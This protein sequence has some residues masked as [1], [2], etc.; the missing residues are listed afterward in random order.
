MCRHTREP[1]VLSKVSCR[2]FHLNVDRF[3]QP[4]LLPV[5]PPKH[6]WLGQGQVRTVVPVPRGGHLPFLG[7]QALPPL[8]LT[9]GIATPTKR[10]HGRMLIHPSSL[11]VPPRDKGVCTHANSGPLRVRSRLLQ[12]CLG[13]PIPWPRCFVLG[14]LTTAFL[15]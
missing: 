9:G 11:R 14:F 1:T 13:D 12:P 5:L 6:G 15:S 4:C 8:R 7:N 10:Y 2:P 3:H